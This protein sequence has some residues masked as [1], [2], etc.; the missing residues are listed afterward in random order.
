MTTTFYTH[1]DCL[2]HDTG[3]GHP[4]RPD[5]LR[6][7]MDAIKSA[8]MPNLLKKEAPLADPELLTLVHPSAHIRAIQD[9]IPQ[10]EGH[11]YIDGDT[12]I[13]DGS[14]NAALRAVGSVCQAVDD[15]MDGKTHNAFC[16]VRPPGHHAEPDQAMGFCLFNNAAIAARHA[17]TTH[18][19]DRVAILDFDVHHG[20]GSDTVARHAEHIFY[21]SSHE[22]PIFPG[23]GGPDS[24][25]D[26]GHVINVPLPHRSGSQDF[27]KAWDDAIFPALDRFAPE[28]IILSAGFDGHK[29]DPLASMELQTEDY[30]WVTE[31]IGATAQKHAQGRIVS[32]LEGG[33]HLD[34]LSQSVVTHIQALLRL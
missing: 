34:A 30:K 6:A 20:N 14:W 27:R 11:Y 13:S 10:G 2:L 26:N 7:I 25:T 3:D 31:R 22:W 21:G 32:V 16:A 15:I 8:D 29:D 17:Q 28:L 1:S 24:N 12:L 33:Y 23:T 9:I 18:A 5:R 4:E 19:L